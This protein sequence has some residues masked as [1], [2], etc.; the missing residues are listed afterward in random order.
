MRRFCLLVRSLLFAT[1]LAGQAGANALADTGLKASAFAHDRD[2]DGANDYCLIELRNVTPPDR[3]LIA[4]LFYH[5]N[6]KDQLTMIFAIWGKERAAEK[7]EYVQMRAAWF[8]SGDF[9]TRYQRFYAATDSLDIM[10]LE[11]GTR[12]LW[13]SSSEVM[14]RSLKNLLIH[15]IEIGAMTDSGTVLSA[16]FEPLSESDRRTLRNCFDGVS[17]RSKQRA[18]KS[19]EGG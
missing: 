15:P 19:K 1:I 2:Q 14:E 9:D 10:K 4:W 12:R 5:L 3:F 8:A 16:Q 13:T 17:E 6:E 7:M 11:N 18:P